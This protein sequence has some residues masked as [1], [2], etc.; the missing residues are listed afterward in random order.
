MARRRSKSTKMLL[1]AVLVLAC[2]CLGVLAA[3]VFGLQR[4][5]EA[6]FGPPTTGLS[7]IQ[8]VNY[9]VQLYLHREELVTPLDTDG[10]EQTFEVRQGESVNSIALRLEDA[11]LIRSAFSFRTYLV[12]S[13][14]DTHIQAGKYAL[15]PAMSP[16]AIAHKLESTVSDIVTFNVLAGWRLDE[17]AAAL[18]TSG[19][20]VSPDEFLRLARTIP[21]GY[22]FSDELADAPSVEGFLF[23]G[24]YQLKRDITAYDLIAAMLN[25]FEAHLTPELRNGFQRQGLNLLQ[26]VTLASIVQKEAVVAEEQPMIASVFLNRLAKGMKLDSDPTV[27]Y[28]LGFNPDQKTWWT[29]P[30]SSEDLQ[31]DS[32]YNTYLH[33]GLPPGP[34]DNPGLSALQAVAYPAQTPYYYF[35]AKCDGS[36][37]H[38]FARTLEEQVSNACK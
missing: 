24:S 35:R 25:N 21:P 18:P 20:N 5:V 10:Q 26:A 3:G 17:I 28:A 7:P 32:P 19:L 34:I 12:Y 1:G 33:E 30:L 9:A 14:L 11:G 8:R 4:Q 36:G 6:Y 16:V 29:N 15:S 13:G 37:R 2:L 23:P 38:V 31:V 22:S 27:Q